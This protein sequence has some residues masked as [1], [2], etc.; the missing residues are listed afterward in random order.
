LFAILLGKD[1]DD[2]IQEMPQ[3]SN[4]LDFI[5]EAKVWANL[6]KQ[7]LVPDD[8][9]LTDEAAVLLAKNEGAMT[10]L[11][12]MKRYKEQGRRQLGQH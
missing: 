9:A 10:D 12:A 1:V 2:K 4:R 8:V 11:L 7:K 3:F 6:L 5:E